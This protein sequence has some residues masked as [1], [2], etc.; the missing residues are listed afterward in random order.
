MRVVSGLAQASVMV[1][2]DGSSGM[3]FVRTPWARGM[4]PVKN[5]A[6]AG[7]QSGL[8]TNA[9]SKAMPRA[10]RPSRF[11]VRTPVLP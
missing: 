6:R 11:G 4:R 1:G 2:T 8:E 9:L 3:P 10:A 7:M 5:V